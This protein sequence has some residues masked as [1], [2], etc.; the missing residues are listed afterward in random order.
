MIPNE[1]AEQLRSEIQQLKEAQEAFLETFER[2]CH[3]HG[4]P[5]GLRKKSEMVFHHVRDDVI[6]VMEQ[7]GM[8]HRS[9]QALCAW[10]EHRVAKR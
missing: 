7:L 3:H 9:V 10:A 8:D 2:L 1:I 5:N 6:P 4:G